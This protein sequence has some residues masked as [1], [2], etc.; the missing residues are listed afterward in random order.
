[1]PSAILDAFGRPATYQG[2]SGGLYARTPDD[3]RLRPA[4]P[5][6]F[7]DYLSLLSSWNW[8][9]LVSESRAIGSRGLVAAA[10][11]QKADYVSASDWRPFFDGKDSGYGDEAEQ[12][13]E[14]TNHIVCTRGPRYDWATLW[15][16]GVLSVAPDGG[17]FVLLTSSAEGWPLL[18]PIE[19]HRIGQRIQN[20]DKVTMDS[21]WT[22][23]T[24][25][26][27]EIEHI[28]T[29]YVGLRITNGVITNRAGAEVAYRVLGSNPDGSDDHD[30]SARDM[31]HV[32]PPRYFSEGRPAPQIAPGL[33]SLIAVD[34]A[35]NAQLDQQIND[36]RLTL[37]NSNETGKQDITKQLLNQDGGGPVTATGTNPEMV[38]R[39]QFR[40]IKN[41]DKLT[42]FESKR[43]ST[44]WMNFD[45]RSAA[46]A[47]AASGWRLEMLDPTALRGA[48]TRAFQDQINTLI[49]ASFKSF[50][51]AVQRCTRYRIAK[52]TQLGM[53]PDNPEFMKWGV[54]QPPDFI[55]DRNSSIVDIA[56]VRAGAD[57]MPDLH[58]RAGKRSREVL[59]Q[60]ARYLWEKH[61]AAKAWSKDGLKI[62]SSDLG[63]LSQRGDISPLDQL[64]TAVDM[65]AIAPAQD[66]DNAARDMLDLPQ[67]AKAPPAPV[68]PKAPAA[69]PP[70]PP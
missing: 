59:Q 2:A 68:P 5:N 57:S 55:V 67:N 22:Q 53:L 60:E 56:L 62:Q 54:T 41:G 42:P 50:R 9:Q 1:M 28:S 17:F 63:N 58:R 4:P 39:A 44:E 48:A 35:R 15:R 24:N 13:L 37:I 29:P 46:T 30:V 69:P 31:I 38:E 64:A 12:L 19:A 3:N 65:G 43:P 26:D 33:L 32:G 27:G 70:N 51:H 61:M 25:D 6:H 45:E 21:A 20:N 36:A 40:Y 52:F 66:I 18:Q 47:I 8:R 49:L 7:D 11:L 14:D 16:L 34:L 23:V 10:L